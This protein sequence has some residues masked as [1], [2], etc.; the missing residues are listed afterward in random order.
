M[1]LTTD[2]LG[3]KSAATSRA[4]ALG[5]RTASLVAHYDEVTGANSYTATKA[6]IV[7]I[8]AWGAGGSGGTFS[9]A[10]AGGGGGGAVGYRVVSLTAG[11][12]ITW[13]IG[14]GTASSTVDNSNGVD[15][16]DTTVTLPGGY[17]LTAGGGKKGTAAGVGGTGGIPSG[18][19][20]IGRNGGD[21]G[22]SNTAGSSPT[23]GGTGGIT[24]TN[25]GGG[26][27]A[28][29]FLDLYP[30]IASGNGSS[31]NTS[32]A[33][34]APGGGSGGAPGGGLASGKGGDGRVII[35][36]IAA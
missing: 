7:I 13:S 5:V 35:T 6:C 33:G 27:G 26:G 36:V 32:T 20:Y 22:D 29:G 34:G 28:A 3:G 25:R 1:S 9:L 18:P 15:G 23:G 10:N 31:G 17:V 14:A 4:L 12:T 21:G 16:G 2:P 8:R 30:N 19:W 11:Q 24:S